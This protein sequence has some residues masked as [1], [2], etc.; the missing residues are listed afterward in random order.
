MER[1]A[2]GSAAARRWIRFPRPV[3][4]QPAPEETRG[5]PGDGR[6]H[7]SRAEP[8]CPSP[9]CRPWRSGRAHVTRKSTHRLLPEDRSARRPRPQDLVSQAPPPAGPVTQAPPPA[10]PVTGKRTY[11][12]FSG[13]TP[14]GAEP[15]WPVTRNDLFLLFGDTSSGVRPSA[16]G[17]RAHPAPG[18][19][20]TLRRR[21]R[22]LIHHP[23]AVFQRSRAHIRR[24]RGAA[25]TGR[26]ASVAKPTSRR[27]PRRQVL[28]RR[29][30][31]DVV[32]LVDPRGAIS[33]SMTSPPGPTRATAGANRHGACGDGSGSSRCHPEP[34]SRD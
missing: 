27:R 5:A 26:S 25:A 10:G 7:R 8:R 13:D 6:P 23:E 28:G 29:R 11:S 20:T 2:S 18:S 30:G 31:G 21:R 34:A 17:R 14:A 12:P 3:S 32:L 4:L 33:A 9:W 24:G 16:A 22:R 15:P 1:L 19:P